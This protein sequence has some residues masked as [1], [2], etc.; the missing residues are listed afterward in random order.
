MLLE[1]LPPNITTI[2][3][4]Q[5]WCNNLYRYLGGSLTLDSS[6]PIYFGDQGTNGSWRIIRDG[7]NISFQRMEAGAWVEKGSF[8]A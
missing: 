7:N 3:D 2:E 8:L 4:A 5:K 6:E 1:L